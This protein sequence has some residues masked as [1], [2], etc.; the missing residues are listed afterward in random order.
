MLTFNSVNKYMV[1]VNKM[2][3]DKIVFFIKGGSDVITNMFVKPATAG[4]RPGTFDNTDELHL[5]SGSVLMTEGGKAV[6]KKLNGED[7]I[8][9]DKVK[10]SD[11]KEAVTNNIKE[12]SESGER[13]LGFC[14]A[15]FTEDELS[16]ILLNDMKDET[17]AAEPAYNKEKGTLSTR[18]LDSVLHPQFMDA[19][20]ENDKLVCLGNFSLMDPAREEVPKAIAT[21]HSAGIRVVM[22]TGD[23]P[24]TAKAIAE[25]IG[26]V[27]TR[28]QAWARFIVGEESVREG[29]YFK[30]TTP[31]EL[32]AS[33]GALPMTFK[34]EWRRN[35]EKLK[36]IESIAI[37]GE[38]SPFWGKCTAEA[39]DKLSG[40]HKY[41]GKGA[42]PKDTL[43]TD[44]RDK[45]A[46]YYK[47]AYGIAYPTALPKTMDKAAVQQ[48]VPDVVDEEQEK[49][50][51]RELD[52]IKEKYYENRQRLE[53]YNAYGLPGNRE[54]YVN[55]ETVGNPCWDFDLCDDFD[56]VGFGE[57]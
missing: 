37:L 13:V 40:K 56:S 33:D 39:Q 31:R 48:L 25:K 51:L 10:K 44:K 16:G 49:L 53:T 21:C 22:V 3:D 46:A 35:F 1:V 9:T 6:E 11:R 27:V 38:A 20:R 34:K 42:D 8:E 2:E 36:F 57:C 23:H 24:K 7:V 18:V 30:E 43:I 41:D 14:E 15:V 28:G 26:I 55:N 52:T 47:N 17:A 19:C 32:K 45:L 12:M 50:F 4:A 29:D 54:D 5:I